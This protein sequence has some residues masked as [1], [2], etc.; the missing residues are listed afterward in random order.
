MIQ[1]RTVI[2]CLIDGMNLENFSCAEYNRATG[3]RIW[4]LTEVRKE[5]LD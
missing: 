4:D 5:S 3:H 2:L 1:D